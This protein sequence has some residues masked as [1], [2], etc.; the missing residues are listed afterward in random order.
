MT[1]KLPELADDGLLTPEVGGWAEDKYRLVGVY[2][3]L[4]ATAMKDKWDSRVY[5]DLFTGAGR[6]RIKNSKRIIP[7]SPMLALGVTDKFDRYIFCEKEAALIDALKVRVEREY[8]GVDVRYVQGDTNT[9]VT[10]IFGELPQYRPGFKVLCFCFVDPF[11]LENLAFETIRELSSR[12]M[13]FL[14]L[15]PSYMDANRNVGPY[16]NPG[17]KTVDRF[18]GVTTWR[19]EWRAAEA[20]GQSFGDFITD[21]FSRQMTG[22]KY[23]YEGL[24]DTKLIR[25]TD[26]NLPLYHLAF[27]S[28]SKLGQ[29]FWKQSR[30]Y[31]E[32]QRSFF[33]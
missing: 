30:K 22:L 20:A 8:P 27:F 29:K 26:K 19:D 13:D 17:N 4:F 28:R 16:A 6:A 23:L 12:F 32:D 33:D 21:R 15:I 11:K 2:A 24:E 9:S 25:S 3:K 10:K 18:L 14:V 5:L 31:S 1:A 7:A